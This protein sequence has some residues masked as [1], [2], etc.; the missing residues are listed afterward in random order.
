MKKKKKIGKYKS[1][2]T[3]SEIQKVNKSAKMETRQRKRKEN[4]GDFERYKSQK[5]KKNPMKQC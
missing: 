2:V 3:T 5:E 4:C 1:D